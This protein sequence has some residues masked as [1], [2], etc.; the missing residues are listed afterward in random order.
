[1]TLD[2]Y[3][4]QL[5]KSYSMRY[6]LSDK[7]VITVSVHLKK[8]KKKTFEGLLLLIFVFIIMWN[9]ICF[10]YLVSLCNYVTSSCNLSFL[11]N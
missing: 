6:L 1:M 5:N 8:K 9:C 3:M 7:H 10:V 4:W 2:G 11:M